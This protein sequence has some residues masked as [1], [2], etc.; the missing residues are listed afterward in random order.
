MFKL[1][2]TDTFATSVAVS[3]PTEDP[4]TRHEG[5]FTATFRRLD[6]RAVDSLLERLR[7]GE[8]TDDDVLDEALVSVSGIGNAEGEPLSADD[9][10]R[11]V[12]GDFA[13]TGATAVAFFKSVG[14]AAEKNAS[15]SR[16][17]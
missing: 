14:G 3:L 15:K 4:K 12:R 13:L 9:A 6:K 5:T 16:G 17:R 2:R 7:S 11:A 10:M 8:A 1:S